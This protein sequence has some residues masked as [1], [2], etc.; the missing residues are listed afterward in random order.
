M[1][2]ND[3]CISYLSQH[4]EATDAPSNQPSIALSASPSTS[5]SLSAPLVLRSAL[6]RFHTTKVSLELAK[7]QLATV[8]SG[9]KSSSNVDPKDALQAQIDKLAEALS[10]ARG[11]VYDACDTGGESCENAKK[12]ANELYEKMRNSRFALTY[13]AE[14]GHFPSGF[15]LE[16]TCNEDLATAKDEV[17]A[18]Q[19]AFAEALSA[20]EAKPMFPKIDPTTMDFVYDDMDGDLVPNKFD[21]C[22]TKPGLRKDSP[23]HPGP[24]DFCPSGCPEIL[25]D[26]G[27]PID[28]DQ[29]GIPD[30]EDR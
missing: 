27:Q 9:C 24:Q 26:D 19:K 6:D 25:G 15:V 22:P 29:D 11:A 23:T 17:E 8:E 12:N 3:A 20:V 28:S 16:N 4:L 13:Y 5:P 30:C 14:H 1:S 18:A 21:A 7:V 2:P 10:E